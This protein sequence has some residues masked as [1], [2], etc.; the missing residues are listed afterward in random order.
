MARLILILFLFAFC[1]QVVAQPLP[2]AFEMADTGVTG[3]DAEMPT[4]EDVLGHVIGTRH[5]VP[6]QLVE[7]FQAIAAAS[8][9]VLLR[10]HGRTYENRPLVH[11]I[12]T[13]PANH[14]RL[15][16]LQEQNLRLSQ[17]PGAFSDA[18]LA[19][20]PVVLYQGYSIHGNE[21]SGSE[22]ALLYL[23]HLAAGQGPQIEEILENAIII[24]DPSFNPDGRDRF[25]DWANRNRGGVHTS[26]AQDREHIEAWPGGRTNHYLFDLNRDWLPAQHPESQGR[27][28]VFYGW[29]PQVLTD[30]HEMG[31]ESSFF[32]M[33]G[34]PSRNNPLTPQR[35]Y[36][37]TAAMAAYHAQW[38]DKIG[39]L[40]YSKESFDDFY[41]GKGSSF[42]DANGTIG[43]LFEQASSRALE[44]ETSHGNLHYAT[45]VRNHFS[46]SLS[47]IESAIDLKDELLKQ[48]RDF[49]ATA[50]DVA[51]AS[52]AK[53]F[54]VSLGRDRTR[55]QVLAQMLQRHRIQLH[56]LARDFSQEGLDFNAGDAFVVPVNQPQARLVKS[57]FERIT[58][59][60]DSLFYDVS[61]WTMPLAFDVDHA[62]LQGNTGDY[63]GDLMGPVSLNGGA[64]VGGSSSYGYI[65][66]WGRY[67]SPRALYR[68]QTA[69]FFPRL[70]HHEV[71][72]K[73]DGQ[74][75]TFTR[76][77]IFIPAVH[78]DPAMRHLDGGLDEVIA[79]IVEA[80]HVLVYALD[81]GLAVSGPDLGTRTATVLEAPKIALLTGDGTSS[82]NAG[83][84]WHLLTERFGIPI[85][86][87][88]VDRLGR[89]DLDRYN[90]MILAGGSY[91]GAP[92]EKIRSWI[93]SGGRLVTTSSGSDWAV[94]EGLLELERKSFDLDS[95]LQDLPYDQL[96]E[97]R[98]AQF[99]G[100]S[101]FE[102]DLDVTHPVAYGYRE[103]VPFFRGSST[104]YETAKQVGA[105]VG[106]YSAAPLLSGYI[107]EEKLEQV[108]GSAAIT[109][110]NMGGGSIVAFMDNPNFRAFWY[111]SNGLF[112]NA[113]FFGDAF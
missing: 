45:T 99:I 68:L 14:A 29:R 21:A 69:G 107:S 2:A 4:P 44:R 102:V 32:F 17:E 7:Y 106:R 13:S 81:S 18:M 54:V 59:F 109:A 76:G 27:L 89:A 62:T 5:T 79:K 24:V 47:T 101:I 112:M 50:P 40:Y 104:F 30:H 96:D 36:E 80:D 31:A 84:V 111:G 33:P 92:L 20:M 70:L 110:R 71:V 43:I 97:A 90:T 12:I 113:I 3:Y 16:T 1:I 57:I 46:A 95:L 42:P 19:D 37:L 28:E 6:H 91:S 65:M 108:P 52:E 9:R 83:E 67:F 8:D 78:R 34:I 26:D 35:N 82:N 11:A 15:A 53:A 58:T 77:S 39:S 51:R 105:T 93:Q 94:R 48:Q 103:R 38:L 10:E 22:A 60:T 73:V 63:V 75:R 88:D 85:S 87:L 55:A 56:Q 49:Y 72:A 41:Y 100:G 98:G 64:L 61:T 25:T 23:Y 74:T 66:E 86:L